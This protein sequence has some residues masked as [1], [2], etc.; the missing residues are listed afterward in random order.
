MGICGV[1]FWGS[2]LVFFAVGIFPT[3][4]GLCSLPT[5][6]CPHAPLTKDQDLPGI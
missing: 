4:S 1:Y 6:Q 3:L 2:N 5:D